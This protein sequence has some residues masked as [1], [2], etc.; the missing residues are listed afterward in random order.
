M[1]RLVYV[2][3]AVGSP[4]RADLLALLAKARE[5]N[6]RLGITGL[7]LFKD[8]DFIQLLE[9]ERQAVRE[10]F[11]A[12]KVDP[13][14]SG[15][16]V[17]LEGEAEGRLFADWSMGFRDLADPEVRAMPGFS[18]YMN[19]PLVAESF[20]TDPSGCLELLSLFKPPV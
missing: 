5:K 20:G 18:P 17:L 10:V 7:L 6:D 4:T 8:G 15:V 3:A 16:I 1:Y 9:G 14:H 2:S 12:I 13:R 19:T 11:D